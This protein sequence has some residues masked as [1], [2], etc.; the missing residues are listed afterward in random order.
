MQLEGDA[1][2]TGDEKSDAEQEE[3]PLDGQ[4]LL[5]RVVVF[6][7]QVV[8]VDESIVH[9]VVCVHEENGSDV[10]RAD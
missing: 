5:C 2:V 9:G 7:R 4:G 10:V 8:L 3:G 6:N 1:G